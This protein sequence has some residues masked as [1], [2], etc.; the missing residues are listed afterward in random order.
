VWDEEMEIL[1]DGVREMQRGRGRGDGDLVARS[2][3]GA[4]WEREREERS[5]LAFNPNKSSC[6]L[7]HIRNFHFKKSVL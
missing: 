7:K 5:Q 6:S 2:K 4:V 1:W 3:R